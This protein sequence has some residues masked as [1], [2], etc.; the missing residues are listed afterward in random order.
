MLSVSGLE[1]F[2]VSDVDPSSPKSLQTVVLEST[3]DR[4]LQPPN[5]R[6]RRPSLHGGAI[7]VELVAVKSRWD[8]EL[9]ET[10]NLS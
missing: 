7:V 9:E 6:E 8:R 10:T 5:G 2:P 4:V 3:G 1:G